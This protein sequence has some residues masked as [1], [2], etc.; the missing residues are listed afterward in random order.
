[1]KAE[2]WAVRGSW[3]INLAAAFRTDW[4]GERRTFGTFAPE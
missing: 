2:V 3:A 1:M 4:R